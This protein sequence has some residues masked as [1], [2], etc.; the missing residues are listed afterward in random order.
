MDSWWQDAGSRDRAASHGG[1]TQGRTPWAASHGSKT[2]GHAPWAASHRIM[3][4]AGLKL[5]EQVHASWAASSGKQAHRLMSPAGSKLGQQAT[6]SRA[7]GGI[8]VLGDKSV[9]PWIL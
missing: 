6:G 2:Q 3:G 8:E 1:K 9:G 7:L 5:W 4:P